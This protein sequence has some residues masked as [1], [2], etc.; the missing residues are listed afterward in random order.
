MTCNCKTDCNPCRCGMAEG[1]Q[2]TADALALLA[3]RREAV[4]RRAQRALLTVLLETGSA[5]IDDVR[6]LVELPLPVNPKVFGAAPGVLAR[7]GLIAA[8]GFAKTCRPTSHA[9]PVTV[10]ALLDC[11]AALRWPADHPDLPDLDDQ[12][13]DPPVQLTLTFGQHETPTVGA[14]GVSY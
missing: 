9:R 11:A 2:R 14:A 3:E 10:W 12:Q 7:A 4:L 6:D 13:E 1:G 5:T 8:A